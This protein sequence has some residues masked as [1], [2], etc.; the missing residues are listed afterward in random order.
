MSG[1][2]MPPHVTAVVD[3]DRAELR[4]LVELARQHVERMACAY[5]GTCT[6]PWVVQLVCE[7]PGD[8]RDRLLWLA[9]AELAAAAWGLPLHLTDAALAALDRPEGGDDDDHS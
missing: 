8:K 9:V 3:Q 2:D 7:M 1:H 5:P 6:G 4:S